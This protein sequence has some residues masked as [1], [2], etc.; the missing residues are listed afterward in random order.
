[1]KRSLCI[2]VFALLAINNLLANA[3]ETPVSY[4]YLPGR[5]STLK[6][7]FSYED[8][9]FYTNLRFIKGS[10]NVFKAGDQIVM[11]PSEGNPTTFIVTEELLKDDTSEY[12]LFETPAEGTDN[13]IKGIKS[14]SLVR[15]G[16]TYDLVQNNY[17]NSRARKDASKLARNAYK[18]ESL[19]Q[20]KKLLK[21]EKELAT[22]L[23][24]G[25]KE[26]ATI[27]GEYS[28]ISNIEKRYN[29]V[30]IGYAPT[31]FHNLASEDHSLIGGEIRAHG[32]N[33]GWLGGFNIT[34]LTLPLYLETGVTMNAGFPNFEGVSMNARVSNF[35]GVD[36]IYPINHR[37]FKTLSFEVPVN[38]T[39]RYNIPHTKIRI[40][41][42]FGF[43]F[44]VN[45]LFTYAEKHEITRYDESSGK[46]VVVDSYREHFDFF[47]QEGTRRFQFGM[48][49]GANFE[50]N[51]FFIG[52]GWNKDFM[53]IMLNGNRQYRN[54][55]RT[56]GMRVNIGW[57]F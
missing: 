35:E 40:S 41:P 54:D 8:E 3:I 18:L 11:T 4:A 57:T 21:E 48:Q 51:R 37:W 44:K 32:F 28:K 26:I 1:M 13:M 39:Y 55:I 2:F 27:K 31:D 20:Q 52:A 33:V 24:E 7:K 46:I 38:I 56:S 22:K 42:Y 16:N 19:I 29:R 50:I 45:A 43:H 30:F 25:K 10:Q 53:P 49:V 6:Y 5:E 36:N 17:F 14:I 47:D 12:L 15:D 34:R 23:S 9:N